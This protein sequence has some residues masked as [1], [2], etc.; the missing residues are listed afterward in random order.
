[1]S[2][3]FKNKEVKLF[4]YPIYYFGKALNLCFMIDDSSN[5]EKL[6]AEFYATLAH[7]LRTPLNVILGALQMMNIYIKNEEY[8][9]NGNINKYFVIM[10][11]NCFRLLRL[12]NNLID[13][14]K[15]DAG[16]LKL[17]LNNYDIIN[18]VE[19][20]VQ[21]IVE[22]A[23]CKGIDVIFDTEVEELVIACDPDKIERVVLNLLS[24]A[25][26]FTPAGGD[27]SVYM[28]VEDDN[29][30]VSIKDTGCGIPKD[31]INTIF[32]RYTQVEN[33]MCREYR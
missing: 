25:I 23:K 27:I 1:M 11:Q 14:T 18:L 28:S 20:I 24:N 7:E 10:R 13:A 6:K 15:V 17:N 21:S 16:Y 4:I 22:Y 29:V 33:E 3:D 5:E 2:E 31:K 32:N 9:Q 26:K 30:K 8:K 19:G 12:I